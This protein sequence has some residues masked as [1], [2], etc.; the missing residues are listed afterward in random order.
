MIKKFLDAREM[1]HPK[2]LE[3]AVRILR[4]LDNESYLYMVHRKEPHPL[5]AIARE[6]NLNFLSYKDKNEIWHILI[7]PNSNIE[8]K[9]LLEDSIV[10]K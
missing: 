8:L 6:H 10:S 9:D 7:T 5:L 4:E 2:P 1:E 3:L